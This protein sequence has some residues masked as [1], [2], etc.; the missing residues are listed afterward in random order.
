MSHNLLREDLG[1]LTF[2]LRGQADV[3]R[4]GRFQG[5]NVRKDQIMDGLAILV[6]DLDRTLRAWGAYGI[7]GEGMELIE[8]ILG[9]V[10]QIAADARD[11]AFPG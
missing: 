7:G 1:K 9:D 8:N 2:G 10:Q 11:T 3:W 4:T 6:R 5:R